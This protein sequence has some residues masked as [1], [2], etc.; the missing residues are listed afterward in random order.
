MDAWTLL[1]YAAGYLAGFCVFILLIP[2]CLYSL[3]R[4]LPVPLVPGPG[5]FPAGLAVVPVAVGLVFVLWSNIGLFVQGGGGPADFLGISISPRTRHL[6]TTGA[7][8]YTRNPMVFG[9]LMLYLG[10]GIS[11]DSLSAVCAVILMLPAAVV[12]LRKTEEER[13]RADF[14]QEYEDYQRRVPMII[15]WFPRQ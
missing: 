10:I 1:R 14:G 4:I 2:F 8:R 15:P 9:A 7:Y 6:V 5:I 11:F 3:S 13:L 12:Y